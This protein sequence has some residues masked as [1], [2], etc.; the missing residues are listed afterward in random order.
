MNFLNKIK[1]SIYSPEFYKSVRKKTTGE[2][3]KYFLGLAAILA[4]IQSVISIPVAVSIQKE[5]PN[6]STKL[7]SYYP[8]ELE[9]RIKDGK[10]S[11]NVEEPYF[12]KMPEGGDEYDNLL[13][14]D[15]KT[16]YTAEQF[17][18]YSA[19]AWLTRDTLFVKEQ[20]GL[21]AFEL[22]K[23]QDLTINKT[24]VSGIVNKISPFFKLI[25]P[26]ISIFIFL[27]LILLYIFRLI[28]LLFIAI[29]IYLVGRA[30]NLN[31]GYKES[32]KIG[33]FAITLPLILDLILTFS[34]GIINF[35][36]IPFFFTIVTLLV[37]GVNYYQAKRIT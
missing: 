30:M 23:I 11:T 4:L 37:V 20:N 12:I 14:I 16:A 15:T 25:I 13:V 10:A 6:L 35:S 17:S 9:V 33:L 31:F 1:S 7:V 22:T 28:Q 3:F 34:K 19:A 2:A 8:A 36:G 18:K 27:G 26:V 5:L 21:R 24:F 32:Y 29:G